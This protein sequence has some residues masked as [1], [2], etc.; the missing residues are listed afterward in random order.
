MKKNSKSTKS[1]KP[2]QTE[3]AAIAV[4]EEA[5]AEQPAPEPAKKSNLAPKFA[6]LGAP[7]E[8]GFG[9]Q[10]ETSWLIKSIRSGKYT[11]QSLLDAFLARFV[12]SG[13]AGEIKR[14]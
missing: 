6:V 1:V 4:I 12:P 8:M 7:D 5:A 10:T 14:K 2:V 13:D 11:K 3:E 9:Q